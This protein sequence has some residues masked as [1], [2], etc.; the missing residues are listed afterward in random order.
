MKIEWQTPNIHNWWS[1]RRQRW[2]WMMLD[3]TAPNA[4]NAK[5]KHIIWKVVFGFIIKIVKRKYYCALS[6]H[7]SISFVVLHCKRENTRNEKSIRNDKRYHIFCSLRVDGRLAIF[8]RWKKNCTHFR[9]A[10][11][12]TISLTRQ[13]NK[14]VR[15][16]DGDRKKNEKPRRMET[17]RAKRKITAPSTFHRQHQQKLHFQKV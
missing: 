16:S 8:F 6:F 14:Q 12:S 11:H 3:S 7:Q 2:Q 15:K 4:W 1:W 5:Q 9:K 17:G 13:V 10:A